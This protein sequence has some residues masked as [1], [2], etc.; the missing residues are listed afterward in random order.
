MRI[1]ELMLTERG[2]ALP[3]SQHIN[4]PAGEQVRMTAGASGNQITINNHILVRVDGTVGLSIA[5]QV[6]M[7]DKFFTPDKLCCGGNEPEAVADNAFQD[8]VFGKYAFQKF[9][10][11]RYFL[12]IL[13]IP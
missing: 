12:N 11:R 13:G 1:Y 9:S 6:V 4:D 7:A 5:D 8:A 2:S 10:G 3:F